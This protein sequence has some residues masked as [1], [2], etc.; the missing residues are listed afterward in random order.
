[1]RV[2]H[3]RKPL[4]TAHV[5]RPPTQTLA[6]VTF[7]LPLA[8]ANKKKKQRKRIAS[9]KA[10]RGVRAFLNKQSWPACMH[11]RSCSP[12]LVT[13][14]FFVIA[15]LLREGAR[16]RVREET[17]TSVRSRVC[18]CLCVSS[19]TRSRHHPRHHLHFLGG[20]LFTCLKVC[21]VGKIG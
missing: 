11:C 19:R 20:V 5:P 2:R 13:Q 14:P 17:A 8:S 15:V 18:A 12:P 6:N 21:V 4:L 9:Q 3:L 10:S 1:M 7:L 16:E